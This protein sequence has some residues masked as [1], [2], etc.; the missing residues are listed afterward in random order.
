MFEA[1]LIAEVNLSIRAQKVPHPPPPLPMGRAAS[2][3]VPR[4]SQMH[5]FETLCKRPAT[6][7]SRVDAC[8]MMLGLR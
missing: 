7:G 3:A 8:C 6:C 4:V 2:A 5:A 1:M